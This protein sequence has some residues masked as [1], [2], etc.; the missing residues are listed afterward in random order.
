M[1]ISL[2]ESVWQV[3]V[4]SATLPALPMLSFKMAVL[5]EEFAAVEGTAGVACVGAFEQRAAWL[6]FA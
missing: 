3:A 6:E 4:G 2:W 1:Y 5:Y